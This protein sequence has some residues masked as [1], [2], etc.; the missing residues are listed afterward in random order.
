LAAVANRSEELKQMAR[1]PTPALPGQEVGSVRGRVVAQP[2]QNLQTSADMFGAAQGRALQQASKAMDAFADGLL[3]SAEQDDTTALLE[4]QAASSEFETD[5]MNN[6]E[7]GVLSRKLKGAQGAS[8]DAMSAF[9]NWA[10]SQPAA[11]T[12]AGRAAQMQFFNKMKASILKRAAAHE[13]VEVN[14]Y[15]ASQLTTIIGNSQTRMADLYNDDATLS[16]ERKS[17]EASA[18]NYADYS[19]LDAE[20]RATYIREQLSKGSKS[21]I[22]AA[23]SKQDYVRAKTLLDR[24]SDEMM[25]QDREAAAKLV[26]GAT[27]KGEGQRAAD[28]IMAKPGLTDEQRLAEARKLSDPAIRD[29]AVSRVRARIDEA[30]VFKKRAIADR[31]DN[32]SERAAKGESISEA[33]LDGLDYY[34][35]KHIRDAEDN[36]RKTAADPDYNRPGDGGVSMDDY[37]TKSADPTYLTGIGLDDLKAKYELNVTKAEW[38]MIASEW[39]SANLAAATLKASDERKINE[40]QRKV[41]MASSDLALLKTTFRATTSKNPDKEHKGFLAWQLEFNRQAMAANAT[42]PAQRSEIINRMAASKVVYDN[43]WWDSTAQA[44]QLTEKQIKNLAEDAD[45]PDSQVDL[46]KQ[47]YPTM[48]SSLNAQ[49]VPI[50]RASLLAEWKRLKTSADAIAPQQRASFL[51]NYQTMTSVLVRQGIPLTSDNYVK[52]FRNNSR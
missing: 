40:E 11:T 45:V 33:D 25:P 52:L 15:K 8:K 48:S 16:N 47:T 19:Q 9:D 21:A 43:D 10:A 18:G 37:R 12:T 39:R 38:N 14:K 1:I 41:S 6:A 49:K 26:Q 31:F 22:S 13:R 2:F 36:A 23:V 51:A 32:A 44:F 5:L 35:R 24:Y 28:G 20:G 7:T 27:I 50:T 4:T 17:I 3:K 34:Q 42:T 46:F 29:E 30:E